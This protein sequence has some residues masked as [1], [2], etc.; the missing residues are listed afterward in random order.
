MKYNVGGIIISKKPHACG[1]NEWEITRTG[2]DIKL[3]C[4]KCGRSVFLSI[5][6]TDKITKQYRQPQVDGDGESNG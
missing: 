6:Q 3:K 4:T 5:D 1:N 2:A